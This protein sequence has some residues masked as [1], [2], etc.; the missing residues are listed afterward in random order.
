[1]DKVLK[2]TLPDLH[3]GQLFVRANSKRFNVLRN[4]RRWGKTVFGVDLAAETV[5]NGQHVGCFFPTYEFSEDFWDE[6]KDRLEEIIEYK[7]ESKKMIKFITGGSLK[8]W[9]L[10]KPRAGRG[11]KYHRIIIDEAAFAKDLKESWEK[12]LRATLTDFRGDAWFLSTPNGKQNYFFVL[13]QQEN[14]HSDWVTFNMP[15][16]TNPHISKEELEEIKSQLDDLTWMQEFMAE[17][18]DFTGRPFA[19]SFDKAKHVKKLDKP[20][21]SLPL[22]ISFDF[23]VDPITAIVGQHAKDKSWIR[24]H[25]EFRLK[26]SDIYEL[27]DAIYAEYGDDYYYRVTGDASGKNRSAMVSDNLNYYKIIIKRLGLT[28]HQVFVPSANPTHRNSRVLTNS[29]MKRHP[30]FSID[31]SCQYLIAD[32]EFVECNANGE[33]DKNTDKHRSHLLDCERYYLYTWH[34]D[35]LNKYN[36]SSD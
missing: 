32:N 24:I 9:S 25:K 7:S 31:E 29:I 21:I 12:A 3:P 1:M 18:V 11:R 19:Y 8:I 36:E 23:N 15:S 35:F 6:L 14:K 30:D 13:N 10:E 22:D 16:E 20:L 34:K 28:E 26:N 17:F 2:V 4:G 33:I 27:C 5:L